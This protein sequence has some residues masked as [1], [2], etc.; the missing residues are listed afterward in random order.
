M[1]TGTDRAWRTISPLL[2]RAQRTLRDYGLRGLHGLAKTL[3][4]RGQLH[5]RRGEA[6]KALECCLK[7]LDMAKTHGYFPIRVRS[8]LLMSYLL[9][10]G[11]FN[12]ADRIYENVLRDLGL[13]HNPLLLFRVI[14]NLY[15]YTWKLDDHLE[16]TVHHLEQLL[17]LQEHIVPQTFRRLFA[18]H[19]TSRI[20]DRVTGNSA[21]RSP[22]PGIAFL[23]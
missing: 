12:A 7:S 20:L 1:A 14:A 8:L 4:I 19:V 10:E 13:V 2:D 16:L 15:L 9:V 21:R 5:L 17:K 3:V 23:G 11:N 22:P 6:D 18:E